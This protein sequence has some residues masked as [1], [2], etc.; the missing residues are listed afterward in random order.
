MT[1]NI[2]FSP[3]WI[4]VC[5]ILTLKFKNDDDNEAPRALGIV[6]CLKTYK[7]LRFR[8]LFLYDFISKILNYKK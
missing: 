5:K 3:S 4:L 8:I 1:F 7:S 2:I 6:E